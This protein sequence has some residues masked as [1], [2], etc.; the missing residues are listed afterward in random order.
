MGVRVLED[1]ILIFFDGGRSCE[2]LF[3]KLEMYHEVNICETPPD[4]DGVRAVRRQSSYR[5]ANTCIQQESASLIFGFSYLPKTWPRA[6]M[7]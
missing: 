6:A 5:L 7:V 4:R 3:A 2:F 1:R